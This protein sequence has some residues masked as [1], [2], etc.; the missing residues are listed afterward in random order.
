[1]PEWLRDPDKYWFALGYR[2]AEIVY[3]PEQFDAT[4]IA[5][6]EDLALESVRRKL[7]LSTSSL[8]INRTVIAMLMRKLGRREAEL[9]VRGWVANLAQPPLETEAELVQA[10]ARGECGVGIAASGATAGTQLQVLV[11]ATAYVDIEAIGVTRHAANPDA[12]VRLIDWLV[13]PGRQ[14]SHAE[15]TGLLAVSSDAST[16]DNVVLAAA[17]AL[18]ASKLAERARYR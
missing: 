18:E 3:N 5:S 4:G 14:K 10:I 2:Q 1:V 7:C 17:G 16:R 6:Y 11:P 9:A 8:A 12:A 15:Q 13:S